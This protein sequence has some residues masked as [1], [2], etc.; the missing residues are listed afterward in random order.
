MSAKRGR[1]KMNDDE[2][3]PAS[4]SQTTPDDSGNQSTACPSWLRLPPA[5]PIA[6]ITCGL[7]DI[8][9]IMTAIEQADFQNRCIHVDFRDHL[10][11]EPAGD[12]GIDFTGRE[13]GTE[14][15]T[16]RAVYC[17]DGFARTMSWIID[18]LIENVSP[19][20][21]LRCSS[22]YHRADT[23][24]RTLVAA[25]NSIL[26][27]DRHM[28]KA[29]LYSHTELDEAD[30]VSLLVVSAVGFISYPE[31]CLFD[32]T[33]LLGIHHQYAFWA[34]FEDQLAMMN[35]MDFWTHVQNIRLRRHHWK[36]RGQAG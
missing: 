10:R 33:S 19:I 25:C 14:L 36:D 34:F 5:W 6:I 24:G 17:Q 11:R 2:Q 22:G 20:V 31:R 26:V 8:Y 29:K 27:G 21:V 15:N 1:N 12:I 30:P 16:I 4:G 7:D 13:N 18:Q 28:F 3:A 35:L 9:D 32:D 23:C